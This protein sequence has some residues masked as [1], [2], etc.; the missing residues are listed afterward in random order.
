ME[1]VVYRKKA[2]TRPMR[3]VEPMAGA[4]MAAAAVCEASELSELEVLSPDEESS[5]P[6]EESLP[7]VAVGSVVVVKVEEPEVMVETTSEAV[8]EAPPA[9]IDEV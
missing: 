8:L 2:A 7:L 5:P 9:P 3:P 4:N 6:S 1:E